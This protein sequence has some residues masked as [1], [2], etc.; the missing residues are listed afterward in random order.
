MQTN[1]VQ[2]PTDKCPLNTA[3]I[4]NEHTSNVTENIETLLGHLWKDKGDFKFNDRCIIAGLLSNFPRI[5]RSEDS[6]WS[7][8]QG[9]GHNTSTKI[10]YNFY[11]IHTDDVGVEETTKDL[12]MSLCGVWGVREAQNS[13][14]A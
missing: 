5:F 10:S 8:L 3:A 11:R 1:K 13:N 2:P 7:Q 14:A 12:H 9:Y 4:L 6:S